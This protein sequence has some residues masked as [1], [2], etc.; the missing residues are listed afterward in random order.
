MSLKYFCKHPFCDFMTVLYVHT[1]IFFSLLLDFFKKINLFIYLFLAALGL[2]CY[3]RVF[4]AA[5]S[6]DY[7]SLQCVGFSLWWL[8]LLWSTGSRHAGSVVVAHRLSSCGSQALERR[9]S[10]CGAR[11]WLLRG[12][13]DL[14]GQG[15]N[16]CPLHWQADS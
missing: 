16:P 10:S 14:P 3:S 8:L 1:I 2:G 15:L 12:M 11:A 13:W 7:S 4:L 5:A 6:G 9:L